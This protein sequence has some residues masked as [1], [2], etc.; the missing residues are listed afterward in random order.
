ML[1][2]IALSLTLIGLFSAPMA[3]AATWNL[4]TV[5]N[6]TDGNFGASTFHTASANTPDERR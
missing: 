1:K 6:G 3:Y 2:K 4:E 5:F